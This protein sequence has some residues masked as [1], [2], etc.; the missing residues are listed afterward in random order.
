MMLD[1]D[2][3][4]ARWL[5]AAAMDRAL[6]H[7]GKPQRYGTQL[8]AF[9]GGAWT[10]GAVDPSVTD[11]ERA[12]WQVPPIAEARAREARMNAGRGGVDDAGTAG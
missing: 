1:P 5:A 9:D 10:L 4:Q 2:N 8:Q 12:W 6:V 11:G 7:L 3:D